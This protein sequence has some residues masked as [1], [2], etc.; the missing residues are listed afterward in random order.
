MITRSNEEIREVL[1]QVTN[2]SVNDRIALAR[3]ILES[4]EKSP[5]PSKRGYSAD[6][7][8]AM[9]KMPQPPPNDE[10]CRRMLDAE[11]VRKYGS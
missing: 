9:L 10:E 2:W 7:V 3:Q 8:I 6:N 5:T 11:R 1:S 4:V